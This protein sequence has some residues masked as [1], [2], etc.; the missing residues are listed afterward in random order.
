[1]AADL[2]ETLAPVEHLGATSATSNA[3]PWWDYKLG[4][5]RDANALMAHLWSL[6]AKA[7]S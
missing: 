7:P 2:H 4:A 6:M 1:M 5:G 3:D